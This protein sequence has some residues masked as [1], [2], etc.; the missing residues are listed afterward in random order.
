[1]ATL[2]LLTSSPLLPSPISSL[3]FLER[4]YSHIGV[5]ATGGPD[6]AIT[7][8]TWNTDNTP[9]G[10]RA[11]WEFV[12]MRIMRVRTHTPGNGSAKPPCVTSLK[13]I[14][15]AVFFVMIPSSRLTVSQGK[16]MSWRG[17]GKS[18]LMDPTGLVHCIMV[19]TRL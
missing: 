4:E 1:M 15:Y 16:P 14:G 2:D 5:L 8:R 12:T 18:I 11:E 10:Q 13:F 17:Y 6:G 3:A 9:P 7:L 19:H